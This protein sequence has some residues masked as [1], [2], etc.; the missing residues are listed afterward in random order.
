MFCHDKI[1]LYKYLSRSVLSRQKRVCRH[2]SKLVAAKQKWY[3]W[4]LPPMVADTPRPQPP[5][6]DCCRHLSS[7]AT[8]LWLQPTPLVLSHPPLTAADTSR[9]QPPSFDCSWHLS[10]FDCSRH[11]S[12]S[13]TLLWLQPTPLVLSHPPFIAA[14]TSRPQPP[15]F[16][17]SWHPSSS[18]TLLWLQL[19]PLVLW[20]QL[21]P[22]VLWLQLTP[23][24]LSHPASLL[25]LKV[26]LAILEPFAPLLW[27]EENMASTLRGFR[28]EY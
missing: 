22:L 24:V 8:L 3:L 28:A 1:F 27:C 26:L 9:P 23:L 2:K 15:S 17:C 20:L 16:D 10:S 12:S 18:A 5:S 21:T 7:S 13:A 25:S 14:D 19:T 4:Q 11:L 6:F